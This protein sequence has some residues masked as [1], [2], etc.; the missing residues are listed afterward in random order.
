MNPFRYHG[1]LAGLLLGAAAACADGEA[2]TQSETVEG[3]AVGTAQATLQSVE[4]PVTGS[5]TWSPGEEVSL[6]FKVGGILAAARVDAG[7]RVRAGELLAQLDLTEIDAGLTRAEAGF[8]KAERD[9]TRARRLYA[10]SVVSLAQLQDAETAWAVTQAQLDAARFDHGFAS[11]VAPSAGRI[12]RRSAQV[13]ELMEPGRSVLVLARNDRG[14]RVTL[15]VADRDLVRLSAGDVARVEFDALPGQSFTARVTE[16]GGGASP[17]TGTHPVEVTLDASGSGGS[18]DRLAP[19]MVARV[20]IIPA[21]AETVLL[22]PV[23]SLIE[24]HGDQ[25][26]VFSVE[27]G[28]ARRK[29]VRIG[30]LQGENVAVL[31]GLDAGA[32]VVTAGGPWLADGTPV[33]VDR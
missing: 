30:R 2:S 4:R 8:A 28:V 33:R 1:L 21:S 5:G 22:V 6:S 18:I 26:T 27:N 16:L 15:S 24:A 29:R 31:S 14:G 7:D 23:E 13:G 10:D 20:E 9:L 11:I 19:G 12:I 3:T 17:L 32:T 25:A